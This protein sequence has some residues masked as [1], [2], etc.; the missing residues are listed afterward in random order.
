ME[1]LGLIILLII[2]FT[3]IIVVFSKE[4]WDYVAISL[5]FA[6]IAVVATIILLPNLAENTLGDFG[7]D[8][9]PEF[10]IFWKFIHTIEFEPIIFLISMQVIIVMIEK[11]KI[12]EWIALRVLRATKGD[13]RKFFYLISI[14][15]S[16]SASLIDD[17]TV[18]IIFVPLVVRACRILRI[19]IAP[20]LFALSFTIN[21]GSLYTPFS[22]SENVLISSVFGLNFVWFLRSFSLYVFP[23]L[24]FTLFLL[25]IFLLRKI[26]PPQ[27][28]RKKIL[29]EIMDPSLVVV[30]RRYFL[31]NSIVF[32]LIIL[33]FLIYPTPWVVALIGALIMSLVNRVQFTENTKQI[34]WKIIFFFIALFL[35]IGCMEM[36]GIFELVGNWV[37]NILPENELLAAFTILIMIAALSGFLAQVPTALVF[38]TLLQNIYGPQANDIPQLVL[39]AFLL[40]INL[41]SNFLPQGAACDLMAL[42]LANKHNVKEFNYKNLLIRGSLITVMHLIMSSLYL[43]IFYFLS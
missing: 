43:T 34:D 20:Y 17:I 9:T 19:K 42:N 37:K 22:S 29:L 11:Q 27:E 6:V 10:I 5:V 4:N 13:H 33:G 28:E 23:I 1:N 25:E 26:T 39:M 12:F 15:S 7:Q 3:A 14:I 32:I 36:A 38:I 35:L 40:G 41:G 31:I 18:I 16:L 8:Q 21:I 30:N 2:L 24:V